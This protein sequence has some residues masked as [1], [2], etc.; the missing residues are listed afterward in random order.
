MVSELDNIRYYKL[1]CHLVY[2][3]RAIESKG[4]VYRNIDI[5][6]VYH[7]HVIL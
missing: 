7:D 5:E 3:R 2:Q 1:V 4:F 6:I